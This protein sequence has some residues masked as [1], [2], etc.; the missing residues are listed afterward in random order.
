[1][2]NKREFDGPRM[3]RPGE[4]AEILRLIDR[5][6]ASGLPVGMKAEYP[7]LYGDMER[8]L[9]WCH[10]VTHRGRIISHT[11]IYPLE[12]VACGHRVTVGGIGAVATDDKYR[13][14]GLMSDLLD[15]STEWM[16]THGMPVSIL[17]GDHIRYARFG[18]AGCGRQIRF[19]INERSAAVPLAKLRNP[20]TEV[21]DVGRVAE[22]LHVL[23]CALPLRV[24][25]SAGEFPLVLKKIGSRVFV[26]KR[27]VRIIAYAQ[28]RG[29][30]R[31]KRGRA[32]WH[33]EQ[34]AGKGEGILSILG[35]MVRKN[36]VD[37]V[38]GALPVVHTDY[39]RTIM[40]ASDCW[41]TGVELLGQVKVV[42][43]DATLDALGAGDLK[44][45]VRGLKLADVDLARLLFGPLSPNELVCSG[46]VRRKL[47]G[48]LPL[49]FHLWPADHV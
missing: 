38:R 8:N 5:V 29:G 35:W 23:Q 28:V 46:P 37:W 42:D 48:R 44:S 1:M 18:W 33:V 21:R 15:Y 49:P 22:E 11:G 36:D 19:G 9:E 20:V 41:S 34:M 10:V 13:G 12:F 30:R 24:E 2:I 7:H 45:V 31:G 17:W 39:L 27:G 6:F 32:D 16:R 26:A 43:V 14:Q 3:A 4:T 40:K 25:R 47:A